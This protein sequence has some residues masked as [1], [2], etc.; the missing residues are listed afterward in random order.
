MRQ[1]PFLLMIVIGTAFI[2]FPWLLFS[3]CL[4]GK[5]ASDFERML[6]LVLNTPKGQSRKARIGAQAVEITND[7]EN[8]V[9]RHIEN[10]EICIYNY[11]MTMNY[12]EPYLLLVHVF[13]FVRQGPMNSTVLFCFPILLLCQ[14]FVNV[15]FD[16]TNLNKVDKDSQVPLYYPYCIARTR[17]TGRPLSL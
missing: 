4:C 9:K 2:P 15:S 8:T 12:D 13:I 14:H 7:V 5:T 10:N 17:H 3:Q 16:L 6:Y 11:L 1:K